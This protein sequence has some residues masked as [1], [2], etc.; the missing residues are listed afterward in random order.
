M[1]RMRQRP[2]RR[3]QQ[4][5][6]CWQAGDGSRD[7]RQEIAEEEIITLDADAS[8]VADQQLVADDA[9]ALHLVVDDAQ[10]NQLTHDNTQEQHLVVGDAHQHQLTEGD[11]QQ[12]MDCLNSGGRQL[13]PN[14]RSRFDCTSSTPGI[15]TQELC[16]S[17]TWAPA[18]AEQ[19][20]EAD[21]A[22]TLC[23]ADGIYI[24][25]GASRLLERASG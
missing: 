25:R 7:E 12:Q 3:W 21:E 11:A 16:S 2:W 20:E 1:R 14:G 9:Q 6:S 22:T 5:G 10:Q 8:T 19:V 24:G 18:V 15:T 17:E 23:S 13:H 4:K